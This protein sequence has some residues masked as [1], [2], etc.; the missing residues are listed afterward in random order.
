VAAELPSADNPDPLDSPDK[1]ETTVPQDNPEAQDK[2]H[3][4]NPHN[5]DMVK[6]AR[7]ANSPRTELQDHQDLP[8]HLAHLD[9]PDKAHTE[10]ARDPEDHPDPMDSP[11]SP[12]T[13]ESPEPLDSPDKSPKEELFKDLPDHRDN[14][15]SPETL[16]SQETPDSPE[17]QEA[18]DHPETTVS[19]DSPDTPELPD[20][21]VQMAT[22]AT[23]ATATIAHLPALPQDTK[24]CDDY[25][26]HTAYNFQTYKKVLTI[27][28]WCFFIWKCFLEELCLFYEMEK[29]A[30]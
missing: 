17:T 8:A 24:K 13:L 28:L 5:K 20:N 10:E 25:L 21:P 26:Y 27:G 16:V 15:D 3:S 22:L 4:P 12:V 19:Q 23:E 30:E 11:D 2:T 7:P 1:T 6:L 14:P 29:F 18:R 9:N